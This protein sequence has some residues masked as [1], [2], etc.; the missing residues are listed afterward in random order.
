MLATVL[1]ADYRQWDT[2][3][4][5]KYGPESTWE[6]PK[7][8]FDAQSTTQHDYLYHK[9]PPRRSVRPVDATAISDAPFDGSTCYRQ[10][11]VHYP[12]VPSKC[13]ENCRRF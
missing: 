7:D 11:Y 3:R 12:R 9:E 4:F 1:T 6:P 5:K 13:C 2:F 10:A 8:R